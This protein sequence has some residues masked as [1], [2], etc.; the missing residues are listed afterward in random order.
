[1]YTFT[2]FPG[3]NWTDLHV[4]SIFL[5]LMFRM[6][7]IMSQTGNNETGQT[8]GSYQPERI[9][10]S[11]TQDLIIMKDPNGNSFTPEQYVQGGATTLNFSRIELQQG[12]YT[13]EQEGQLLKKISFNIS[14]QE[15]QLAYNSQKDLKNLIN[16]TGLEGVSILEPKAEQISRR[17]QEEQE[18]IPLWKY[19]ILGAI[20][21]LILEILVIKLRLN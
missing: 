3:D 20:L 9:R 11:N 5:P 8:I 1:M 18:G 19:F 7:Q 6:T 10:T 15:S 2:I 14:D 16:A 12:N 17:I 13:I 4:K 21:F